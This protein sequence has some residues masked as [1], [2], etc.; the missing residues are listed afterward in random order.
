VSTVAREMMVQK[1]YQY[2]SLYRNVE[3]DGTG[4]DG[5]GALLHESLS[6]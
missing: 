3:D 4:G 2:M 1:H 5:T 6:Y